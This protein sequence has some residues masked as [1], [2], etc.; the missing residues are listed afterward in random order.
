MEEKYEHVIKVVAMKPGYLG[1]RKKHKK[2]TA[3]VFLIRNLYHFLPAVE[4][5]CATEFY[6][7]HLTTCTFQKLTHFIYYIL[8]INCFNSGITCFKD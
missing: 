8:A 1:L 2:K 6:H 4:S 7:S 3:V 5:H